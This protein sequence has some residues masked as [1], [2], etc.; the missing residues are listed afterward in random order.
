MQ[1]RLVIIRIG[2]LYVLPVGRASVSVMAVEFTPYPALVLE[3]TYK[4]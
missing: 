2:K 4:H 1:N 3:R